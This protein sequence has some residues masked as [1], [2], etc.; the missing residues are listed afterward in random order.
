MLRVDAYDPAGYLPHRKAALTPEHVVVQM[1]LRPGAGAFH[2]DEDAAACICRCRSSRER[3]QR[4]DGRAI[5][6]R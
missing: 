3:V 2:D 5:I 1:P 6:S 4:F